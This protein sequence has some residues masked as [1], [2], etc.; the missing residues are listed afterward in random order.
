MCKSTTYIIFSQGTP[1]VF[2][3]LRKGCEA[4]FLYKGAL[5]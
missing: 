2:F 4:P 1:E 5:I 3:A